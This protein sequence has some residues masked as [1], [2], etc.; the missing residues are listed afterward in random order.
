MNFAE[1]VRSIGE[2][3]GGTATVKSVYGEP[4]TSGQRVVLPVAKVL[5]CFGGGGGSGEGDE[6]KR[7]GGGGGGGGWVVAK[8]C[9]LVDVSPEGARFVYYHEPALICAAVAAGFLLG[10]VFGFTRRVS[11]S[12][13]AGRGKGDSKSV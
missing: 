1:V 10:A 9:G 7:I 11:P 3:I 13:G 6:P 5:C 8:P 2:A 4:V 12:A